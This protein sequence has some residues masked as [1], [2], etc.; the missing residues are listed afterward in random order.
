VEQVYPREY[1]KLDRFAKNAASNG[2][3]FGSED[4]DDDDD[5]DFGLSRAEHG[6]CPWVPAAF[7]RE[8]SRKV[9]GGVCLL[10]QLKD[11]TNFTSRSGNNSFVSNSCRSSAG[12][13]SGGGNNDDENR[14]GMK[15]HG[16]WHGSDRAQHIY[17]IRK[18]NPGSNL[19][20]NA[21]RDACQHPT[22]VYKVG[23]SN[24]VVYQRN[25][26]GMPDRVG[27]SVRAQR[28]TD[29]LNQ[30]YVDKQ[31]R[32]AE[33]R[34]VNQQEINRMKQYYRQNPVYTYR[35]VERI[36]TEC[37]RGIV[38]CMERCRID[39]GVG[40]YIDSQFIDTQFI[41]SQFIDSQ[42][43]DTTVLSTASLSTARF[44]DTQFIDRPF[45]RH[46]V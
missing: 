11:V 31:V 15:R 13:S 44:I 19:Y 2:I 24:D 9:Y 16:N 28:Q 25:R 45:Y 12:G 10:S 17:E 36:P 1:E 20:V 7:H 3:R 8:D 14:K 32:M 34:G 23:I 29:R 18:H 5:K 43:I 35:I 33:Q 22:L 26:E 42:F 38:H 30:I 37:V 21:K 41:D 39:V 27:N 6:E 46:P 4:D 40:Q